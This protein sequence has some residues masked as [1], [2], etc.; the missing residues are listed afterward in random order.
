MAQQK[1][2]KRLDMLDQLSAGGCP[3]TDAVQ[4]QEY[5]A[6]PGLSEKEK[7]ARLKK[8]LQFARE[9]STTLP[10]VDPLFRIQV[11]LPNKRR[12][13]KTAKEFGESLMAFLGK[14]AESAAME[15]NLFKSSLRKFSSESDGNN[16]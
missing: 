6:M 1:E 3:F 5:L 14:K 15:Y 2:R 4:V 8:E 9:S 7:Q 12:R 16:N 10:S 13:D 11:T